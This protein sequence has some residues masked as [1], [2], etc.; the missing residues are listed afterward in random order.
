MKMTARTYFVEV[1]QISKTKVKYI[2]VV[3]FNYDIISYRLILTNIL[4]AIIL[5][6]YYKWE[7]QYYIKKKKQTL[8]GLIA[9]FTVCLIIIYKSTVFIG[10][11]F[12]I[13]IIVLTH[14][15]IRKKIM[16]NTRPTRPF[17]QI[18]QFYYTIPY[19]SCC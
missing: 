16:K 5:L 7:Y 15:I 12:I 19:C 10:Y 3:L 1:M 8:S 11:G 13:I 18:A 2:M 17:L 6:S 14:L 9:E 4:L